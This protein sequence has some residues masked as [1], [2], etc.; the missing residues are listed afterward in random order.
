[1]GRN[2]ADI[3][4]QPPRFARR[5]APAPDPAQAVLDLGGAPAARVASD[6]LFPDEPAAPD[7]ADTLARPTL[8]PCRVCAVGRVLVGA[9]ARLCPD[10][11]RD[12]DATRAHVERAVAA[13]ADALLQA[14][15]AADDQ[16]LARWRKA[17]ALLLSGHADAAPGFWE[18]WRRHIAARS[19]LGAILAAHEALGKVQTWARAALAEIGEATK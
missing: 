3:Q 15:A 14:G 9:P 5:P 8:T 10:C 11:L 7:V 2:F 16:T 17:E 12:I 1:M 6:E 18:T 13:A 4:A 19:P